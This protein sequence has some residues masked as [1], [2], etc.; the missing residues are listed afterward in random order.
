[1]EKIN[2]L[3][4]LFTAQ[5]R[6]IYNAEKLQMK[7]FYDELR[8]MASTADLKEAIDQSKRET[9]SHITR[10]DSVFK[11]LNVEPAEA[12]C[13]GVE[14]IIR[15]TKNIC[16]RCDQNHVKDAAV[17]TGL[18]RLNH[19]EMAAYGSLRSFAEELGYNDLSSTLQ[20]SLEEEKNIDRKLT[21]LAT[22]RINEKA[23]A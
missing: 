10:L 23:I 17:I 11:K 8:N 7:N 18:Q 16:T 5:T 15:D 19:Y 4:D 1:M 9:E 14:G 13:E 20:K 22:E 2:N 6:E 12:K 3:K 21:K